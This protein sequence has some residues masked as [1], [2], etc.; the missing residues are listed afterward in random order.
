MV[1][2]ATTSGITSDNKSQQVTINDNEWQRGVQRMT[3]GGTT[4]E[5]EW[6]WFLISEQNNNALYNWNIFSNVFLK[7]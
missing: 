2:R 5:S 1:Q 3:T 6:E 7:R 4:N